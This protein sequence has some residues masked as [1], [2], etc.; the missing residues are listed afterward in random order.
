MA[1]DFKVKRRPLL[2]LFCMLIA[3]FQFPALAYA[4]APMSFFMETSEESRFFALTRGGVFD[5]YATGEITQGTSAKLQEFVTANNVELA[6]IH[7]NSP[8]GSLSEG[9]KLGRL[10]RSLNFYTTVGVYNP[11]YIEDANKSA[12]CASAC[13]YAYAGGISRFLDE[14]TG[15]LGVHQFSFPDKA[16][17]STEAVQQISGIIVAYLDE[18]GVNSQAFTISTVADSNGIFWLDPDLA[19]K[20][21]FAN[22]G[23]MP[24]VAEIKLAGMQPYLRIQQDFHDVTSRTLFHC[25]QRK[26]SMEFGIVT[27]PDTSGMIMAF[28]KKSY[29]ELDGK[30]F[31]PMQGATGAEATDSTVW[32][33]RTLT[34]SEIYRLTSATRLEGWVDGSG[35]V[36][37]GA[38]LD[39]PS[40]RS[41]IMDFAKQCFAG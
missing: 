41:R 9:M 11:K 23:V 2:N 31:L 37:W 7:F 12:V 16:P 36:R 14:Y 26:L 40:V 30:E 5:I 3:S 18:M 38:Q 29:L 6:K 24:P 13:A 39:M 4:A 35:A 34:V 27:D 10:I 28:P 19:L 22:N 21:N 25:D 32:I 17:V 15:R 1:L 8:G 33:S 20:L